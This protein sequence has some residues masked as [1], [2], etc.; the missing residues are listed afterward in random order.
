MKLPADFTVKP[1]AEALAELVAQ[2]SWLVPSS[3]RPRLFSSM[4]DVFYEDESGSI[5]WLSTEA[6][7][8]KKVAS[9]RQDFE[10]R[11]GSNGNEW[12]LAPILRAVLSTGASLLPG[13]CFGYK[14]LPIMGGNFAPENIVPFDAREWYGFSGTV[15][16]QIKDVPDGGKV[17][18]KW[19]P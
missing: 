18:I 1:T 15:H 12:F 7:E 17:E 10:A 5:H 9:S 19:V 2:W 6:G 13:Q 3:F 14:L 16:Q 11:L 4:G 8:L